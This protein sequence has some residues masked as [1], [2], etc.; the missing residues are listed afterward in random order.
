MI[1]S[2]RWS[3]QIG[4]VESVKAASDIFAPVSGEITEIN[5]T[6]GDSPGLLNKS[7]EEDGKLFAFALVSNEI[8][9]FEI[10]GNNI[11]LT[12]LLFYRFLRLAGED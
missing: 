3:E 12:W 2:T 8:G 9:E 1:G 11:S 6:L 4:A 10:Q 7:A 5:E